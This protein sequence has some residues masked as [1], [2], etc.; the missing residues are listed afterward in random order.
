MHIVFIRVSVPPWPIIFLNDQELQLAVKKN[1]ICVYPI[2]L[3][4]KLFYMSSSYVSYQTKLQQYN[5]KAIQ[6]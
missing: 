4:L 6:Q 3:W 5:N 1:T 2:H